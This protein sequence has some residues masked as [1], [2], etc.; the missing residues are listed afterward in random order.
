MDV[1]VSNSET[2][3][4]SVDGSTPAATRTEDPDAKSESSPET[5]LRN[6]KKAG[7]PSSDSK[8]RPKFLVPKKTI[9]KK[10]NVNVSAHNSFIVARAPPGINVMIL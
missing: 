9:V 4:Q 6:R 8:A 10:Q 7:S 1:E 2:E 3:K 5:T